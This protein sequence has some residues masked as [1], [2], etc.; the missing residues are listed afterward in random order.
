MD[1]VVRS[2]GGGCRAVEGR[3]SLGDP[4][5][6]LVY[7]TLG[8]ALD[9]S[10]RGRSLDARLFGWKRITVGLEGASQ[11][12]VSRPTPPCTESTRASR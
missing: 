12:P 6:Q 3:S 7:G 4:M 5:D 2:S 1:A 8:V 9:Y 11:Q 10:G